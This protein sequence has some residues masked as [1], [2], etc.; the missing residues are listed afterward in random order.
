MHGSGN[1]GARRHITQLGTRA[2]RVNSRVRALRPRCAAR[3]CPPSQCCTPMGHMHILNE[4][5]R[6]TSAG[7]ALRRRHGMGRRGVPLVT[8]PHLKSQRRLSARRGTLGARAPPTGAVGGTWTQNGRGGRLVFADAWR[9][10]RGGRERQ[11]CAGT[12]TFVA[13]ASRCAQR[14]ASSACAPS[15]L[16]SSSASKLSGISSSSAMVCGREGARSARL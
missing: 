8:R 14:A 1:R 12:R 7:A 16:P 3:G 5:P 6:D 4:A 11:P 9:G 2:Q 10:S 15:A 13:V